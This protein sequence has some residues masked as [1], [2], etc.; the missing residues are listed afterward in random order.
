M[1]RLEYR[2]VV[3]GRLAPV[4]QR[5]TSTGTVQSESTSAVFPTVGLIAAW[6]FLCRATAGGSSLLLVKPPLARLAACRPGRQF[7]MHLVIQD[8]W[9]RG[10]IKL[11]WSNAIA[12]FEGQLSCGRDRFQRGDAVGVARPARCCQRRQIKRI[13]GQYA[14]ASGNRSTSAKL[15]PRADQEKCPG[16][17]RASLLLSASRYR[18]E[19]ES[20]TVA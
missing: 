14:C 9:Q 4:T 16:P 1:V 20:G 8:L 11:H 3:L 10:T 5:T 2:S 18:S 15:R 6:L 13:A 7:H 12:D 19:A 17:D